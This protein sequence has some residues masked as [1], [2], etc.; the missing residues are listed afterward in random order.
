VKYAFIGSGNMARAIMGG[1]VKTGVPGAEIAVINPNNPASMEQVR[2]LCGAVP[3][4]A[5][6]LESAEVI[7]LAVKPQTFPDALPIYKPHIPQAALVVSIMAGIDIASLEAGFPGQRIVRVMPNLNLSVG[8]GASGYA[9]GKYATRAD[10]A[11]VNAIFSAAGVAVEVPERLIDDV[12][13]LSGSGSAYLYLMTEALRDVA[14]EDGVPGETAELLARQTLIGA[15]KLLED[16]GEPPEELRRRITS[17]KGT[18][19]AAINAMLDMKLPEAV[20][21]GYRANKRRSAELA[22]L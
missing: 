4:G 11:Q 18:T 19:E 21:A 20:K 12:A 8:K 2:E 16:T 13:A 9:A 15:A 14:I 7:V 5:E 3:S 1:M 6:A 10:C 22:K 17:K